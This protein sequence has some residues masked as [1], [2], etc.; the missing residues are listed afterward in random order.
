MR[1]S[2]SHILFA[3][4]LLPVLVLM[5]GCGGSSSG[6]ARAQPQGA[7]PFAGPGDFAG[8]EESGLWG[9]TTSGPS[10]THLGCL[11]RR[12]YAVAFT[13]RNR[14]ASTV[15]ITDVGGSEPAPRIIR[16][17]AVQVRLA[18]PLGNG[19]VLVF[20]LRGWSASSL[21][22]VAI[23]PEKRVV[24]QSNFLMGRCGE[25]GPHQALTVNRSIVV[26]YR[27]GQR[28]GREEI[29]NR[30]ARIILT[31]GPTTRRCVPPQGAT[32]LAASDLTCAVAKRAAI[33]CH[34]LPH[35]TWGYC[36]AASREWDCTFTS[37][38]KTHELC[39]LASKRQS[40]S[41]RWR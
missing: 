11:P 7:A 26:T 29:A 16:R 17:V 27:I 25:L 40:I 10:G 28:T 12:R 31:R 4:G 34:R 23:P 37:A 13:L 6:K 36:A 24:V 21:K 35:G 41:V 19:D 32:G 14:S 30:T 18:P 1:R 9:D 15:T 39:W 5:V 33:G 38:S 20:I 8:G 22:P 3:A 2:T